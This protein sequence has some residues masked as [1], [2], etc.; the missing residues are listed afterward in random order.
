MDDASSDDSFVILQEFVHRRVGQGRAILL[1]NGKNMGKGSAVRR[2]MLT[3]RGQFLIFTDADLAY[4]ASEINKILRE[5]ENGADIAIA[6]RVLPESTYLISPSFFSYLYTRHILGRAFNWIVRLFF[7]PGIS[8]TQAGLKGFRKATADII[9]ARQRIDRFGFD[10]EVLLIAK[11]HGLKIREVAVQF[12][13]FQ[14]P[15]TIQFIRD[16]VNILKDLMRIKINDLK[17]LYR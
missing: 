7:L 6:S 12:R 4:P 8:D 13:Y 11:R 15:T 17:R 10:V 2:G 9:F 3:A 16:A 14:E 1:R 5:L